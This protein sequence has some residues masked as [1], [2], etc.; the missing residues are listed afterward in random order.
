M[1]VCTIC[2]HPQRQEIDRAVAAR[3]DS[4]RRSATRHGVH[5]AAIRRRAAVHMTGAMASA[6]EAD[7]LS[8]C[9]SKTRS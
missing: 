9:A 6:V 4:Y 3:T 2:T 8:C 1:R 7:L 5:E